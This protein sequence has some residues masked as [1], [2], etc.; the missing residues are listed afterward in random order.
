MKKRTRIIL[1]VV[2][3]FVALGAV[4]ITISLNRIDPRLHDW[5]T[6]LRRS[7]TPTT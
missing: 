7:I 6:A 5:V 2:I 1:A 3:A 4:G